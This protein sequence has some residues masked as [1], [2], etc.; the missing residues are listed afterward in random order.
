MGNALRASVTRATIDVMVMRVATCFKTTDQFV[1][2]FHRL[3]TE[4]SCFIPTIDGKQI[5]IETGF[6][7]RLA[8]GTPMLRG[9]CV[10]EQVWLTADN[11]YGRAGVLL[12]IRSITLDSRPVF[13][14]IQ[15]ARL[16]SAMAVPL[17]IVPANDTVPNEA[18]RDIMPADTSATIEMPALEPGANGGDWTLHDDNAGELG[19]DVDTAGLPIAVTDAAHPTQRM[20]EGLTIP[21]ERR[22][23]STILGIAPLIQPRPR[24]P[25][26]VP[27]VVAPVVDGPIVTALV[28]RPP[29]APVPR[30]WWSAAKAL[31]ARTGR[32]LISPLRRRKNPLTARP[33]SRFARVV[34]RAITD[35]RESPGGPPL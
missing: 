11:P 17:A 20:T 12:G 10:V 32:R 18:P 4:T 21:I 34:M 7:I 13:E 25:G 33:R 19:V 24:G 2:S 3:C 23:I 15:R 22:P 14:Q 16:A 9:L 28:R 27:V 35:V 8:D 30:S 26:P 6:S 31:L 5:G 1:A 29:P